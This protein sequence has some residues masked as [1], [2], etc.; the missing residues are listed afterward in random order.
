M[1]ES[2]SDVKNHE[3]KDPKNHQYNRKR[4]KHGR[5]SVEGRVA[6]AIRR[7]MANDRRSVASPDGEMMITIKKS[8]KLLCC[9]RLAD[10]ATEFGDADC[11][12]IGSKNRC[13]CSRSGLS[14]AN[15]PR[16]NHKA[17]VGDFVAVTIADTGAGIADDQV[18]RIFE[19]FFTTKGVGEGTGLG[20]SQVFGFAK[21]S[22]GDI[23]VE[24]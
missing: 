16:G 14:R 12:A 20:L 8:G 3:T 18:G 19:P 1:N 13:H 2:A 6:I 15:R 21:Q 5:C 22:G 9:V 17:V 4:P 23:R 10:L 7:R 24:S 11:R